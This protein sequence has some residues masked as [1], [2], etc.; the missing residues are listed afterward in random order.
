MV[1]VDFTIADVHTY[2]MTIVDV[3]NMLFALCHFTLTPQ[4]PVGIYLGHTV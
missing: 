2:N 3:S 1:V 4:K